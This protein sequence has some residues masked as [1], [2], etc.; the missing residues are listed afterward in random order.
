M[1]NINTHLAVSTN[2][3][4]YGN[5]RF[6]TEHSTFTGNGGSLYRLYDDAYDLGFWMK[7]ERTGKLM[8]FTSLRAVYDEEREITCWEFSPVDTRLAKSG[9]LCIIFND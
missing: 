7:S 1:A 6:S 9:V 3:F 5:K 8:A 4:S 2:L